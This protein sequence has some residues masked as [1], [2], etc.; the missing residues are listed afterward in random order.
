M[1]G[2]K[3]RLT[4]PYLPQPTPYL[5]HPSDPP[6]PYRNGVILGAS[7]PGIWYHSYVSVSIFQRS[8][9]GVGHVNDD[10]LFL[11]LSS[12]NS[13]SCFSSPLIPFVI[14]A[15]LSRSLLRGTIVNGAYS[16]QKPLYSPIFY[17][18]YLVLFTMV[19]RNSSS[20]SKS[21]VT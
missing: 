15:L 7:I 14:L 2:P 8:F 9:D 4:S 10:N 6:S 19:P 21:G 1:A 13:A 18:Q 5:L 12:N 11:V 20:N 17:Y 16:T 3:R